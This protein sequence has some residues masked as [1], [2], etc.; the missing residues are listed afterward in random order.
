MGAYTGNFSSLAGFQEDPVVLGT[1]M[2]LIIIGGI[3]FFVWEDWLEHR[4]WKGLSLYSK[5]V[6]PLPEL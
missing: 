3:G 6:L 1:I 5:L 4:R 2:A